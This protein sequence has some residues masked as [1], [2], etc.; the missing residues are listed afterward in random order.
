MSTERR[1]RPTTVKV[2]IHLPAEGGSWAAGIIVSEWNGSVR[3]DRREARAH[4]MPAVPTVPKGVS[5][6]IWR[7]YVA[8][9]ETV[10]EAVEKA[11]VPPG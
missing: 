2:V 10:R 3:V 1:A 7:A 5:E 4:P 6:P 11:A 9:S 8:L